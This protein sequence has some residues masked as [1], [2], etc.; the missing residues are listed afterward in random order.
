M[1]SRS[2]SSFVI[3]C[4]FSVSAAAAESM[5]ISASDAAEPLRRTYECGPLW[6]GLDDCAEPPETLPLCATME[7]SIGGCDG[8]DVFFPENDEG[9]LDEWEEIYRE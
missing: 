6:D 1:Q 4:F 2:I 9:L 3:F 5:D 7:A 8:D